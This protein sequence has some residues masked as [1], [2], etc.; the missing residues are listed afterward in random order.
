MCPL[1]RQCY[2]TVIDLQANLLSIWPPQLLLPISLGLSA[3]KYVSIHIRPRVG[4]TYAHP[5]ARLL[6]SLIVCARSSFCFCCCVP[7]D[8]LLIL[9]CYNYLFNLFCFN[10]DYSSASR[11]A[12]AAAAGIEV[13]CQECIC[14]SC[15]QQ[16]R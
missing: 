8:T 11:T 9:F 7:S 15:Q 10:H 5:S 4:F 6:L 12:A 16:V 2:L 1:S 3:T 14:L 13:D